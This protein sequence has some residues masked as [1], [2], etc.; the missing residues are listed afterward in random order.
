V[1]TKKLKLKLLYN[2]QEISL[3]KCPKNFSAPELMVNEK[4]STF[5]LQCVMALNFT[6]ICRDSLEVWAKK[7]LKYQAHKLQK[8][9]AWQQK[10]ATLKKA[11]PCRR[12][13]RN[14]L[15]YCGGICCGPKKENKYVSKVNVKIFLHSSTL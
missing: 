2:A 12:E 4:V 13:T 5:V 14:A 10:C 8:P 9:P 15:I 3:I 1:T 7:T 11:T 6:F